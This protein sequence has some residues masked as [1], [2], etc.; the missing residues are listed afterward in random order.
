MT[1]YDSEGRIMAFVMEPEEE[2]ET[3]RFIEEHKPQ[4]IITRPLWDTDL[5]DTEIAQRNGLTGGY[6]FG[7]IF[8]S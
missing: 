1:K 4:L 8:F 2:L 7:G 5:S 6:N 3:L